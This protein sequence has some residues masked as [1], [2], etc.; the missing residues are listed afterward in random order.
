MNNQRRLKKRISA[1]SIFLLS[2][3][4]GAQFSLPYTSTGAA[5]KVKK[6]KLSLRLIN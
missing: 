2:Y 4:L 1:V 6:V 3:L 5:I